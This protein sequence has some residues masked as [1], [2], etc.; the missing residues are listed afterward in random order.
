ME[1]SLDDENKDSDMIEVS[2]VPSVDGNDG[3][4]SLFSS[5]DFKIE[6]QNLPRFCGHSQ[7]KKLFSHKLK[8]NFHKL[9]PCGPKAN[10]M[11]ICFKNEEDKEKAIMVIDGFVYKGSKLQAKSSNRQ[12]DPFQKRSEQRQKEAPAD[13]RSVEE[14]LRAAVCPTAD[15]TYENQLSKKSAEV[16]TLVKRLGSEVSRSHDVLKQW[17]GAKIKE[18]ETIAPVCNFVR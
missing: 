12:K 5:E 14:R 11:Y 18:F 16:Q 8:L 1:K 3:K 13:E 10:Y 6:V 9:K 4:K 15:D 17:V 2:T 7:L